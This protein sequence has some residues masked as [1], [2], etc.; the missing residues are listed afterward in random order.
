MICKSPRREGMVQSETWKHESGDTG[1]SEVRLCT[2]R[3][4]LATAGRR[5]G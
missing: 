4:S 3:S 1:E 2:R 5:G